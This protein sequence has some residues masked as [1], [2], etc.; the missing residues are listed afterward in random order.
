MRANL[1]EA[2]IKYLQGVDPMTI[3]DD[4]EQSFIAA[5]QPGNSQGTLTMIAAP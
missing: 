5:R 1:K 3:D 4:P 2:H